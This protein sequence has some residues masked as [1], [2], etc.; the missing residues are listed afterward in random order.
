MDCTCRL[1]D[2]RQRVA[3]YSAVLVLTR[4][5]AEGVELSTAQLGAIVA[6]FLPTLGPDTLRAWSGMDMAKAVRTIKIDL[7]RH[8][9]ALAEVPT[10]EPPGRQ[11]T[12]GRSEARAHLQPQRTLSEQDISHLDHEIS[13]SV[14]ANVF[15][16]TTMRALDPSWFAPYLTKIA[17]F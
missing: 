13:R 4:A 7:L 16:F 12:R 8:Q 11:S 15:K 5:A 10:G 3:D 9:I 14:V 6:E 2:S 1:E 17:A